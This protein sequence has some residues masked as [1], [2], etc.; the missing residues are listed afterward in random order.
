MEV[1]HQD[2]NLRFMSLNNLTK[3]RI[4][5][6]SSKE[7]K[8]LKWIDNFHEKSIF[9]ILVRIL[10]FTVVMHQKKLRIVK[11]FHSNHQFLI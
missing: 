2:I 5:T 6:F 11:H 1:K 4:D 9:G 8:T 3:Y 10:V 7:P